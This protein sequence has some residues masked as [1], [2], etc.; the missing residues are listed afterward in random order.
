MK[1]INCKEQAMKLKLLKHM[2]RLALILTV[3]LLVGCSGNGYNTPLSLQSIESTSNTGARLTFTENVEQ[4]SA[5]TIGNYSI[6]GLTVTGAAR[7]GGDN[8]IVD[9]ITSSQD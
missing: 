7:D 6:P 5:E 2:K 4:T 1:N 9:L 3:A 8:S